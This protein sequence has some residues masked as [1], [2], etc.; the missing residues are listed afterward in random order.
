[1]RE[2]RKVETQLQAEVERHKQLVADSNVEISQLQVQAESL[3]ACYTQLQS[4]ML[5]HTEK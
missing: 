3:E 4:E 1:M 5:T 2:L